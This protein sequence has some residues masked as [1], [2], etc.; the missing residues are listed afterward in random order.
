MQAAVSVQ[1]SLILSAEVRVSRSTGS[2]SPGRTMRDVITR[3]RSESMFF[4]VRR[5]IGRN[6]SASA[7]YERSDRVGGL[8]R[9]DIARI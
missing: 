3:G 9:I 2:G 5:L 7:V 6:G 1:T 4:I 8:A